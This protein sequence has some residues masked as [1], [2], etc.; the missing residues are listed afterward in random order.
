MTATMKL[1]LLCFYLAYAWSFTS[2][3]SQRDHLVVLSHGLMGYSTDL[4]YL[5]TLLREAGCI[6]LQSTSNHYDKTLNGIP[7]A[8]NRLVEEIRAAQLLNPHLRRISFVGN[9]LGGLFARYTVALLRNISVDGLVGLEPQ[10]FMT[11]S[12]ALFNAA[13]PMI[14]GDGCHHTC[15][16]PHRI[17]E[18]A[19]T[20]SLMKLGSK[21]HISSRHSYRIRCLLAAMNCFWFRPWMNPSPHSI[22]VSRTAC[23]IRWPRPRHSWIRYD[24]SKREDCMRI[25]GMTLWFP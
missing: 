16:L 13:H 21:Y 19:T 14:T 7:T 3:S 20:P 22:L 15:R 2:P 17:L 8:S 1:L 11:V 24:C 23:C 18:S 25:S 10:K 9:S 5:A 6:V 4:D 12:S